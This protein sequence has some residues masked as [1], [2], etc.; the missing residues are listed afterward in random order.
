MHNVHKTFP[1]VQ[2][3]EQINLYVHAGEVL[4]LIGQNG[5]GK[6]A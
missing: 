3:L 5:A 4:G 2:A 1:G 6:M